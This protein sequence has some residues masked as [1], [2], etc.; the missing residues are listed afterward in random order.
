MLGLSTTIDIDIKK[1]ESP[2]YFKGKNECTSCGAKNMLAFVDI[3][4]RESRH[5]IRAFDHITCKACGKTFSILWEKDNNSQKMFPSAVDHNIA[6]DFS[7]LVN[8][9]SS[10]GMKVL[11]E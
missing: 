4:G 11:S 2:I 10:Y 5:E 7:N 6:R 3:F 8:G 9:S 1:V